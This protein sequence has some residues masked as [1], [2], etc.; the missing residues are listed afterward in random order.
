MNSLDL[1]DI[2]GETPE[3]YV[4]DAANANAKVIPMGKRYPKRMWLIA[5]I[6]A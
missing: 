4:L 5:A 1:L 6:I 3:A 2:I